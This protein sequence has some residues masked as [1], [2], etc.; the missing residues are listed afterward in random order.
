M[1]FL[2]WGHKWKE[3]AAKQ[4]KEIMETLELVGVLVDEVQICVKCEKVKITARTILNPRPFT[5]FMPP[6]PFEGQTLPI[7]ETNLVKIRD[8]TQNVG[9][10][11]RFHIHDCNEGKYALIATRKPFG[12]EYS[13]SIYITV[14]A[15]RLEQLAN[16][17]LTYLKKEA[18]LKQWKPTMQEL[19]VKLE[20]LYP[21][22]GVEMW[23]IDWVRMAVTMKRKD[24]VL[25]AK[26]IY[27]WLKSNEAWLYS[28]QAK[29]VEGQSSLTKA[30]GS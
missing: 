8:I 26:R 22:S 5:K 14:Q 21:Q 27:E 30:H 7:T 15:K 12:Q 9:D 1:C 4:K 13:E 16:D 23:F 24:D 20:Q 11:L 2:R 18:H 17:I 3:P 19:E 29:T 28:K 10:F 6:Y 25:Q